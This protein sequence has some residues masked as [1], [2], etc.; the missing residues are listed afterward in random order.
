LHHIGAMAIAVPEVNA[1]AGA[2]NAFASR[3]ARSSRELES[4]V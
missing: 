2:S 3:F 4:I 1:A